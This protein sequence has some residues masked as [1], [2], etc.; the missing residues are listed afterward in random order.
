M[1]IS[2]LRGARAR[3]LKVA[4]PARGNGAAGYVLPAT[5]SRSA[6]LEKGSDRRFRTLVSDLFTIAARMEAVRE[7]LGRRSGSAGRNTAC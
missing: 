2:R 3:T 1:S 7:H 6:L 4:A 5:V